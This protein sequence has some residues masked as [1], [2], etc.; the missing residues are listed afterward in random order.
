MKKIVLAV[1]IVLLTAVPAMA[2]TVI[3]L[4]GTLA[5]DEFKEFSTELGLALSY[6]PLAPAEPLGGGVLPHFDVGVEITS[7]DINSKASYW[8]TKAATDVPSMLLFPKLH[9]Q[10]GLPVVPIDIGVV[11]SKVPDSDIKLT[12]GE[13]K[14]AILKGS[15]LTPALALRAAYTK[16]EG[17]D[18]LDLD[19]K[20]LDVSISK[21]FAML[22]PYAGIG[23]VRITSEE[24]DPDVIL[25]KEEIT[26]TKGFVGMKLSLL[27]V[28]NI[29]AEADFASINMYSFRLNL[30]F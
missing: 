9:A 29:V 2:K 27:P 8:G 20:S 23:L 19:T 3:D 14:W 28:L 5:Q 7:V 4:T 1:L 16:L 13:I 17:V 21:G 30:H 24:N 11:Y 12:G 25:N 15:T 22:T 6:I 18:V 26:E 10:L